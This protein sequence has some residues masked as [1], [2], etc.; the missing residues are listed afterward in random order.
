L[1]IAVGAG[2]DVHK[3]QRAEG[4]WPAGATAAS[5]AQAGHFPSAAVIANPG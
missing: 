2:L 5:L 3:A 4:K 1:P